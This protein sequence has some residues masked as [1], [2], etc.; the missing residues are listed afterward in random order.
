MQGV[1]EAVFGERVRKGSKQQKGKEG[2]G[3]L[4][5]SGPQGCEGGRLMCAEGGWGVQGKIPFD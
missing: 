5:K 2:G 1:A 4:S 3:G